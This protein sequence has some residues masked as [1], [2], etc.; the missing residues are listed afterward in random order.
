MEKRQFLLFTLRG[1]MAAFGEIAVG[2]RRSLWDAPSKSGVFGFLAACLGIKREENEQL[3]ALENSFGFAVRV[4][5]YGKNLRDFHTAQA[6]TEASRSRRI[7]AGLR[8]NTRKDD[9]DCDD[10][11]TMLSDRYYR[12]EAHYT[13]ALWQKPKTDFEITEVLEA[14]KSP[15]FT[16]YLGRKSC[17][18]GFPPNP[19]LVEGNSLNEAFQNFDAKSFELQSLFAKEFRFLRQQ[20]P[21]KQDIWFEIDKD[22]N[23]GNEKYQ[24]RERRD[25]LRNRCLWQFSNRQEGKIQFLPK[26]EGVIE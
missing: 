26:V 5:N 2:Q 16:P 17:P 7:K 20:K 14:I 23:V 22:L 21:D 6:P 12:L 10:L 19:I 24:I 8:L 3:I 15:V 11:S 9:L 18:I 13:I 4:E 1:P 25:S